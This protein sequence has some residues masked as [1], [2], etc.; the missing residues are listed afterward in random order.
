MIRRCYPKGKNKAF[1]VTYDDGVLQDVRFVGLLNQYGLKGTFNLN[2]ELMDREFMWVHNNGMEVKRLS[3]DAV[4]HLYDGH[5]IAAHTLTHPYLHDK[6][7]DALMWEIGEDKRRLEALFG[8][9]VRG[10]GVPFLFYDER[11]ARCVQ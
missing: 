10:F 2:S 4:R 8:R 3:R 6:S 9:E 11:I 7:D 5:E 1:N